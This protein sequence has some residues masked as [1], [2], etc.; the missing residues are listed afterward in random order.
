[1]SAALRGRTGALMRHHR[2]VTT[3]ADLPAASDRARQLEWLCTV[4]LLARAA[5]EPAV[6][7]PADIARV[8]DRLGGYAQP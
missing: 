2:T 6:L 1:M 5:G 8:V 7:P 3:G 4:W